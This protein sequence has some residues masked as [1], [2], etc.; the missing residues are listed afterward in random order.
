MKTAWWTFWDVKFERGILGGQE[1]RFASFRSIFRWDRILRAAAASFLDRSCSLSRSSE[2]S[3]VT[4][5]NSTVARGRTR[6]FVRLIV[7]FFFSPKEYKGKTQPFLQI[8]SIPAS[9]AHIVNR[10]QYPR[11][12]GRLCLSWAW[13]TAPLYIITRYTHTHTHWYILQATQGHT[14]QPPEPSSHPRKAT[15]LSTAL[16]SPQG[17]P[18]QPTPSVSDLKHAHVTPRGRRRRR[19]LLFA[20]L[21]PQYVTDHPLRG[22]LRLP[23]LR[24]DLGPGEGGDEAVGAGDE[25]LCRLCCCCWGC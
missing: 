22:T 25:D 9:L 20:T 14:N 5:V 19:P 2:V 15:T 3:G 4:V 23:P 24:P 8:S 11:Y 6:A 1:S 13:G 7:T 12:D 10:E 18:R 17:R 21:L 16:K